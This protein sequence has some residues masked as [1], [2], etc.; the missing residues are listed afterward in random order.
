MRNDILLAATAA[1]LAAPSSGLA[2]PA[3]PAD[4][5]VVLQGGQEGT[6]FGDMTVQGE[7]RIRIEFDR[8]DLDL[9]L[10]P[11]SAP[12]LDWSNTTQVLERNAVDFTAPLLAASAGMRTPYLA[13]PWF[14]RMQT[15]PVARF[16][17]KVE[18]VDRWKLMVADSQG[19]T[20]ATF[21]GKGTVPKEIDW[22]GT[23]TDGSTALPGLTYSYVFEA[24]DVAGNK[25]N[26][27]GDGFEVPA[28]RRQTR[29]TL[30]LL[31]SGD[32]VRD[33]SA[34]GV[35]PILMEAAGRLNQ[36]PDTATPVQV[37]ATA[38]SFEEAK[39]LADA[40]VQSLTPLVLG[41]SGRL[42]ATTAVAADAPAA[43]TVA[44]RAAP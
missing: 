22:D 40:V 23:L 10:D 5:S 4:T 12:G 32:D 7:D 16:T 9:K 41:N 24:Y 14:S 13:R 36:L 15:G 18:G 21:D 8:P 20:A 44:I 25:R 43:G 42:R 2:A 34:G 19:R 28:Y 27:V 38:R 31:F 29:T 37:E 1:L 6:V 3:A 35:S 17:P 33:R 26:F 30:D 11:K 39:S